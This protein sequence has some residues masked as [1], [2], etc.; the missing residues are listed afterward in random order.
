MYIYQ[1]W[2]QILFYGFF[3]GTEE[4]TGK[5]ISY[6]VYGKYSSKDLDLRINHYEKKIYVITKVYRVDSLPIEFVHPPEYKVLQKGG[7]FIE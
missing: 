1:N 7:E 4:W 2:F 6:V 5:F 3:T